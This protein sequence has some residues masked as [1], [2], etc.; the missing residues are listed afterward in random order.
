VSE[1]DWIS[2]WHDV[3]ATGDA[4]A[5]EGEWL[6]RLEAGLGDGAELAEALRQLRGAGKRTMAATLLELAADQ[7]YA[8]GAWAARERFLAELIRLG[9]GDGE[10]WRSALEECVRQVWTGKPSLDKMLDQFPLRGARKPL[11]ALENLENWLEH[12]VGGVF[13]MAGRG[14]GRVVEANPKL[15]TLRLDFE[16]EKRVPMPIE[17]AQ[18]FLTPLPS[19]HF[20]RRR[21]ED[22]ATL[23][24]EAIDDPAAALA[25]MLESFATPMSV[26]EIKAAFAGVVSEEQWAGWWSKARKLPRL[27]SA[28]SG[29]RI[30]YRLAGG[31]GAEEEIRVEFIGAALEQKVEL[32]RR[33]GTRSKELAGIFA[34]ELAAAAV[35]PGA[36]PANA[37]EGLALA[38]RLGAPAA[39]VDRVQHALVA[40]IGARELLALL[41]DPQQR[42]AVLDLV[43]EMPEQD[44][45]S[46]WGEWI[47][48]ESHPR[49][50]SHLAG[51][52]V[53]AGKAKETQAFL[54]RVF[55]NPT[56][57]PA[58]FVWACELDGALASLVEDKRGGA[59]LVRIVELAER[60]EFTAL[61]N[62]LK[63]LLSAG[64]LA[65]RIVQDRLTADQARRIV[66][67][68]DRPGELIEERNWLRRAAVARFPELRQVAAPDVVPA[69]A[70]TV[71]RIQGELRD[72][73]EKQIPETVKA[74]QVAKEHGDLSEN[75][76]YHA[77]RAR[78][79]FLSARA[80]NLQADLG[81]VRV[82]DPAT[83]DF[84]RVR[85]GTRVWLRAADSQEELA[86]VILGPYEAEPQRGILSHGS[87]AAQ[88]L[89]ERAPGDAVGF[90]G[91]RWT[92][93]RIERAV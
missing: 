59:L 32:A 8:D 28:G 25:A 19:G 21:L 69:L 62:R 31:A 90:D 78:Q 82:I 16:R 92:V 66:Q 93:E 43:R 87:E 57:A 50:L 24:Q 39:E 18:R 72:L 70:S 11:D 53:E 40:R 49:V 91:R 13:A 9:I 22:K 15:G 7:A 71:T 75:F 30:S 88:G 5:I 76:E 44:W 60:K 26:S 83:V 79:E 67:V 81:R 58:A 64:G 37:W 48:H 74:I 23:A 65:G 46:I 84:S 3:V 85:V 42:E 47:E 2:G 77:A 17:A 33:H 20:L 35:A 51:A 89:L 29:S 56:K 4:G 80:A 27:V 61:R 55:V 34:V 14:A 63:E 73:L 38:R 10:Q 12:D 54:D 41:A 86:L 52:L 68:L 36:Q 45:P 1:A 6:A